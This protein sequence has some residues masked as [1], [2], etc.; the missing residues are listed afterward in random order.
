M[1]LVV[2]SKTRITASLLASNE[3]LLFES[4]QIRQPLL[5]L[6]EPEIAV[7]LMFSPRR[8]ASL[9]E[10][11]KLDDNVLVSLRSVLSRIKLLNEGSN[12][13]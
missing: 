6:V 5:Q 8:I 12:S 7:I 1:L 13:H 4:T 10:S 11:E 3:L 2:A 9:R